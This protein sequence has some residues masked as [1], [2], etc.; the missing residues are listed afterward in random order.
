MTAPR[1]RTANEDRFAT[2]FMA[3]LVDEKGLAASSATQYSRRAIAMLRARQTPREWLLSKIGDKAPKG[4]I[5]PYRA[6]A[7]HVRVFLLRVQPALAGEPVEG[8]EVRRYVQKH[9]GKL[10]SA[11]DAE[12]LA[13]FVKAAS[14]YPDLDPGVRCALLLVPFT[15]LRNAEAVGLRH[16][17]LVRS[18]RVPCL[19]VVGKGSKERMVPLSKRAQGLLGSY[20]GK[21][22][23][24]S[25]WLFPSSID[26]RK[27]VSTAAL[28]DNHRKVC[29]TLGD[30]WTTFRVHDLR[31][32]FASMLLDKGVSIDHIQDLLGHSSRTT[33]EGYLHSHGGAL[34]AAVDLL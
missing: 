31:H 9:Q 32:T 21:H 22:R 23:T 20:V 17:D 33:T 27:H 25:V 15:G 8:I 12:G 11:L 13:L 2:A 3:Y 18:G 7:Q 34:K 4:T 30:G 5:I 1:P 19:R 16:A 6:T 14:T 28:R 26:S 10:S 24:K 29:A